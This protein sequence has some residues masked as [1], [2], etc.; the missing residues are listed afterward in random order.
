MSVASVPSLPL[1]RPAPRSL[2]TD[3][4]F[5]NLVQNYQVTG[6]YATKAVVRVDGEVKNPANPLR[7]V[8]E[9]FEPLP[10]LD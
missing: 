5:Y 7:T 8:V 10:P 2:S 4:D 1:L 6:E 3:G 9:K